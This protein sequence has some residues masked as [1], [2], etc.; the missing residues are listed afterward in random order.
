MPM[1]KRRLRREQRA[2]QRHLAMLRGLILLTE[3]RFSEHEAVKKE[4]GI[5]TIEGRDPIHA[6]RNLLRGGYYQ[7]L[8][9][10]CHFV[11]DIPLGIDETLCSKIQRDRGFMPYERARQIEMRFQ[12][13]LRL[14]AKRTT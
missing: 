10:Y 14:I 9:D 1:S 3:L 2:M 7:F 5:M 12:E 8:I 4:L 13:T 11:I 6:F